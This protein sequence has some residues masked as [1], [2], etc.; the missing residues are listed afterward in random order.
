M[1]ILREE[2]EAYLGTTIEDDRVVR[3]LNTAA[4]FIMRL[5]PLPEL[6]RVAVEIPVYGV[7]DLD[8]SGGHVLSVRCG[9][10]MQLAQQIPA[11][12]LGQVQD[13]FS[14]RRAHALSPRYAIVENMVRLFP[15]PSWTGPEE[16]TVQ[17]YIYLA[18]YPT[19]EGNEDTVGVIPPEWDHAV[20]L[21]AAITGT[22]E[23][24]HVKLATMWPTITMPEAPT[25]PDPTSLAF[26]PAAVAEWTGVTIVLPEDPP[27]Y[28]PA[29]ILDEIAEYLDN[30]QDI[31]LG[32]AKVE[33]MKAAMNDSWN[34]FQGMSTR[35]Q[36]KVQ[37]A[38]TQA[39]LAQQ[40]LQQK[41]AETTDVSKFNAMKQ[42][43]AGVANIT[44]V[45]QIYSA[46]VQA[47]GFEVGAETQRVQALLN[48]V[49]G[50]LNVTEK[51]LSSLKDQWASEIKMLRGGGQ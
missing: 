2:L 26:E 32:L 29:A 27:I 47:Y 40:A 12:M 7:S 49:V 31:E 38:I 20:V 35:Y 43:E 24:L 30:Q 13:N 9:P 10:A 23:L 33:E 36:E 37:T 46:R 28:S 6:E 34:T 1:G 11:G 17:G 4:R 51:T 21:Q 8:V 22:L 19:L 39:Q 48:V 25:P 18:E 42:L 3:L 45:L 15:A 14:W 41:A 44:H 16:P 50:Q 5:V